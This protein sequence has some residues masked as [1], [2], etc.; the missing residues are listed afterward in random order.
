MQTRLASELVLI[1]LIG[2]WSSTQ[3]AI[4]MQT[5]KGLKIE[6]PQIPGKSLYFD[7]KLTNYI[8]P[9]S[10]DTSKWK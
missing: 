5:G 2:V 9:S 10:W 4:E 7:G 8:N 3:G 1:M 6:D